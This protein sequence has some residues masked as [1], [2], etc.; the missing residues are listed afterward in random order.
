MG[1]D[2]K[3]HTNWY[4]MWGSWAVALAHDRHEVLLPQTRE[5]FEKAGPTTQWNA[6][7]DGGEGCDDGKATIVYDANDQANERNSPTGYSTT[8][9]ATRQTEEKGIKIWIHGV[10]LQEAT[11]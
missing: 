9:D 10:Q 6:A 11:I 5:N 3:H 8:R 7:S 1:L 4:W 2:N